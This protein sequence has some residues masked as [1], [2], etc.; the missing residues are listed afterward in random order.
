LRGSWLV[1]GEHMSVDGSFIEANADQESR[2][3]REQLAEVAKVNHNV[4]EYLSNW[5][6]ESGRTSGA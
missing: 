1:K 2:I 6:G 3:P 5:R 4:R